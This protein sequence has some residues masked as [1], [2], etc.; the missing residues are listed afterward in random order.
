MQ[1]RCLVSS[2]FLIFL[3]PFFDMYF[4]LCL[5]LLSPDFCF[6]VFL[7]YYF[8]S[9]FLSFSLFI[10]PT[11]FWSLLCFLCMFSFLSPYFTFPI[12]HFLFLVPRFGEPL[13]FRKS[14][15]NIFRLGGS[16]EGIWGHLKV[17]SLVTKRFRCTRNNVK[18]KLML[19]INP[20]RSKFF[21]WNSD[22]WSKLLF[23]FKN[24]YLTFDVQKNSLENSNLGNIKM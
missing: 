3:L 4:C 21:P 24:I 12:N 22:V 20:L 15:W 18:K 16:I 11:F 19:W 9:F 14:D 17:P 6:S 2:F 23:F 13:K 8:S 10:F 1:N 7:Y 5:Q